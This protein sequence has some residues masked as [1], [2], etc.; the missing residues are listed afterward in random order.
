[1]LLALPTLTRGGV[2]DTGAVARDDDMEII[3]E[4]GPEH[5]PVRRRPDLVRFLVLGGVVGYALGSLLG[6]LGPDA[7]GSSTL[8]EIILLGSVGLIFGVLLAAVVYLVADRRS[9][10]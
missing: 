10:R 5:V 6:W 4:P 2:G 8:Q 9:S 3:S 1:M 7:P